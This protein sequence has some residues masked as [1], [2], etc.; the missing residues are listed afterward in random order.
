M[1]S[2]RILESKDE[3]IAS[4]LLSLFQSNALMGCVDTLIPPVG[5]FGH[6]I[7]KHT[8]PRSVVNV[9]VL[10]TRIYAPIKCRRHLEIQKFLD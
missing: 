5:A 6:D 1:K 8:L 2:K 3:Q 10:D 4:P 9:F 7:L